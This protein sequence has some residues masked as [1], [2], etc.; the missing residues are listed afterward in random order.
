VGQV[1]HI[2]AHAAVITAVLTAVEGLV[3]RVRA[4]FFE[5]AAE[6]LI[7]KSL[8]LIGAVVVIYCGGIKVVARARLALLGAF[9]TPEALEETHNSSR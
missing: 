9:V 8:R 3:G 7:G 5:Y 1:P 4:Y 2:T 6:D